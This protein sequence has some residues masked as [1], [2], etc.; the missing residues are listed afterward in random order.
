MTGLLVVAGAALA[1]VVVLFVLFR[2]TWR[3]AEPN[4]ALI[5]SGLRDRGT[6]EGVSESLGFRIVTGKG[7]L[8][9]PGIQTVRRLSLDLREAELEIECVTHQ[10]IPLGVRG[11]V[12]YKVG[13]DYASI[14]NAAR[15]FLDQQADMN[16]RV[17]NVFAGHLRAIVGSMTVEEMI[18]DREKLTQL[19]RE[20]SGTEM[21]KLG[22][23]VD[24]LQ[25][26]EIVDPTGYITNLGRPHN[27][28]VQS[29]AR[30][31]QAGAD[32]EAT[33]REQEAEALKAEAVRASSVKQAG[34]QAEIDRAAADARQAGPL[35]EATAKQ[36]V[37]VQETRVAELEAQREEQR[38][39]A[40]IRKPADAH[41][42][43]QTTLAKAERD[44]RISAAEAH[45]KEVELQAV[46]NSQR[47]KVE[48]GAD[49]ERVRLAAG[50]EAEHV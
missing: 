48:A 29:Q 47:V 18:R 49:A 34:Y 15:R 39:Q 50:A 23:I 20:S 21:E 12:I 10:G 45:A 38:L 27:A 11:V 43:E 26:Q 30:I 36:Q 42:Y 19:T 24:S 22:L 40:T 8:V 16:Q 37:V 41:A 14:A 7:T 17:H 4:E 33:E 25:I 9:L 6:P 5:I 46:A 2:L 35:S 44:A 1:V 31:A 13:D 3:V 28:A 32:R